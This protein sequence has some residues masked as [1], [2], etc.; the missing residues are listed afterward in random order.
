[1]FAHCFLRDSMF[2]L[3]SAASVPLGLVTQLDAAA[4]RALLV[5]VSLTE[6]VLVL[7]QLRR[8]GRAAGGP[9]GGAEERD[10]GPP[11]IGGH[12]S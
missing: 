9:A 11:R 1:M 8:L 10:G 3:A 7:G 12:V 5:P 6:P 4:R 2:R